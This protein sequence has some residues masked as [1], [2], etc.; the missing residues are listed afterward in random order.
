MVTFKKDLHLCKI[1]KLRSSSN[2]ISHDIGDNAILLM[3]NINLRQN[4]V[5]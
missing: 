4:M 3:Q 5:N 1:E 2:S